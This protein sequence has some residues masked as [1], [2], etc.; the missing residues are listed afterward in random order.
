M[1][2]KKKTLKPAVSY[3]RMS[4]DDQVGSPDQQRDAVAKLADRHG[5]RIVDEYFDPGISGDEIEKRPAF[6]K[7]IKDAQKDRF[8]AILCWDQDRFGRFNIFRAGTV[9]TP[10]MD[11]GVR[12]LTVAQG[13]I[14]WEDAA[15]Q[16]VYMVNQ[17]QKHTFLRDLGRNVLR[18]M[19]ANIDSGSW[20]K[21]A[22]VGLCRVY[23]DESGKE[24]K[25]V[26]WDEHFRKPKGWTGKLAV[27]GR[28]HEV[29]GM[30][31][32]F[33][34][35]G[36]TDLGLY[37]I[38]ARLAERGV[39]TRNGTTIPPNTL[40]EYLSNP[41]YVGR[42]EFGRF[43]RGKFY[44]VNGDGEIC[45]AGDVQTRGAVRR[46]DPFMVIEDAHE[47]LIDAET[48]DRVQ[49]KLARRRDAR[50][51]QKS[52]AWLLSGLL[53]CGLCGGSMSGKT[54][55]VETL[56][57]RCHG[58]VKGTCAGPALRKDAIENFVAEQLERLFLG[59]EALERLREYIAS[60]INS[61]DAGRELIALRT[62]QSELD[63]EIRNGRRN[64]LRLEDDEDIAAVNE[65]LADLRQQER[66]VR[67]RIK[68]LEQANAPDGELE[69]EALQNVLDFRT[70]FK[71][72]DTSRMRAVLRELIDHITVNYARVG[73]RHRLTDGQLVF[74]P[75]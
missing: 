5:Y 4:T 29:E 19:L 60:E 37:T 57:Y 43:G 25:R 72:G 7:M 20:M 66:K 63:R 74:R 46:R 13:P 2:K 55:G 1:A 41:K 45:A 62:R 35:Y 44:S 31:W 16:L 61:R 15:G 30:R 50:Q 58:F 64:V 17:Q 47:A 8:Q 67:Q 39:R 12:L 71:S 53:R 40:R 65:M 52:N 56:T 54:G 33:R 48:F 75:F 21:T 34:T 3:I 23:Y 11:A 69:H 18:G 49:R 24:Q 73:K 70:R 26:E 27:G 42:L 38:A 51:R 6:Q 59:D 32:A 36:D 14:D 28:T 10:L 22:P 68:L 9:I